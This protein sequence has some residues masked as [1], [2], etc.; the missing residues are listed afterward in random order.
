MNRPGGNKAESCRKHC[1]QKNDED[2]RKRHQEQ[3]KSQAV[4]LNY[5]T[6]DDWMTMDKDSPAALGMEED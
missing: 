2:L 1:S 3:N 6:A 5:Q 4:V